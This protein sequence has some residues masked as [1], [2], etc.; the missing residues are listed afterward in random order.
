MLTRRRFLKAAAL[1]GAAASV[2]WSWRP[3][4]ARRRL[5]RNRVAPSLAASSIPKFGSPLVIPPAMPRTSI[6]DGG[7]APIDYYEIAVRQFRQQILPEGMPKTTVWGYGSVGDA[8]TFNYPSFTVEAEYRRPVRVK[9]VNDLVDADGHYLPHLLPIDQT[10]HWAN[11]PG[12]KSG[13]DGHGTDQSPYA[14]P[15][16]IVTHV[17]GAHVPD[18]ADG[19]AEAWFLPAASNIPS[20]YARV[21]SWYRKFRDKSGLDW[22]PGSATFEYPNDQRASTLWYHDHALGMTRANVYAGPAGFFLLRGGPG[23]RV[24]DSRTGSAAV[25]PGPAPALD[26]APGTEYF[27]IPIA[28]QDRSFNDDGSLFYPPNRAFFEG[29]DVDDTGAAP[30]VLAIPFA[31]SPACEGA[32]SD[33]PPIWNPEFFGTTI[34]VNGRTWPYLD[35]ARRRYR[36]RFLNGC[37]ARFLIL[38]FDS[39]GV[40]VWQIGTEGG[41]L[42]EPVNINKA[43]GGR[44]LLGPAERADVIVDFRNAPAGRPV[45]LLNLGPDEPF[46]GGEPGEAFEAADPA[47]TGQVME[48]RVTRGAAADPSTPAR[49]LRLPSIAAMRRSRVVRPLSLNEDVSRTVRVIVD[50]QG[51]VVLACGD[52][53]ADAFGP[54]EARL[55]TFDAASGRA[56]PLDWMESPTETPRVGDRE[57]WEF[58]NFTADAHPIHIHQV[59]FRVVNRQSLEADAEGIAVQ[60]A[61][62]VG[63]SRP[64][65]AWERGFK[66][67]V[68]AYPGAVTRVQAKFD[69]PGRYVWH[70]HILEHEDNEMMRPIEVGA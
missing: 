57:T 22:D 49:F 42:P 31:P 16:P 47:T 36:L 51:S 14:G 25:L 46:G 10:L 63:G 1:L 11:P 3:A 12:G 68:I 55:G 58:H 61:K 21:G 34:V 59:Q 28:I 50:E 7:D 62:L 9:W 32:P 43:A 27:E 20:G 56:A 18:W 33:V 30:P 35:V 69:L 65:E 67:T 23:D 40:S 29:L 54:V 2:P 41:F 38:A 60:P 4:A 37:Q 8:G 13:R 6:L 19:Y 39:P 44:L 64:P 5:R 26:D 17:H 48:F 66:D 45:R 70:C 53:A 52:S 15:V 24:L